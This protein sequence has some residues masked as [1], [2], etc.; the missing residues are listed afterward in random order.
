MLK[1]LSQLFMCCIFCIS[2]LCACQKQNDVAMVTV[3]TEAL[4]TAEVTEV[5]EVIETTKATEATEA[6]EATAATEENESTE[7][8][9]PA[10]ET[11]A[12][13]VTEATEATAATEENESTEATEPTKE[14]EAAEVTEPTETTEPTEE[15]VLPA[16]KTAYLEHIETMKDYCES[17]SLFYLDGDDIPELYSHSFYT[18]GS[19]VYTYKNGAISDTHIIHVSSGLYIPQSGLLLSGDGRMGYYST[20]VYKLTDSGFALVLDG[21][22]IQTY[23]T[24]ENG[25]TKITSGYSIDG[26]TLSEEEFR[27][28]IHEVFD[29][30]Q[31]VSYS[32]YTV[33]YDE[34][35][36]QI[37]DY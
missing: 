22:E 20:Y 5:T 24:L 2:M 4:E 10:K 11:E 6:T 32:Q 17:Y 14:T 3:A 31:S 9:E 7:A 8:T 30:A 16:W 35:R 19:S 34:I 18:G 36:K 29:S 25:D 13:E 12:T 21:L 27:A 1:N 33:S 28:V 15:Q 23:E 37:L 26:V